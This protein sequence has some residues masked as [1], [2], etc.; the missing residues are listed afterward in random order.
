MPEYWSGGRQASRTGSDAPDH[1]QSLTNIIISISKQSMWQAMT[2]QGLCFRGCK[3]LFHEE[4]YESIRECD[5]ERVLWCW[6][7]LLWLFKATQHKK[8]TTILMKLCN[9][10]CSL[11][12]CSLDD[13]HNSCYIQVLGTP[14]GSLDTMWF[15]TSILWSIYRL[16]TS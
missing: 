2:H 15:V 11:S 5:G 13:K 3:P 14:M 16:C 8:K 12:F 4:F 10:F 9:L 1:D 6:T 7:Y